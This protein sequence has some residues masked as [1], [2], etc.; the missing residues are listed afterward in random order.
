[1]LADSYPVIS[2]TFVAAEA[3]VLQELGFAVRIEATSAARVRCRT[4]WAPFPPR[5]FARHRSGAS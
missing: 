2:E 4:G 3:H 5:T 1:V